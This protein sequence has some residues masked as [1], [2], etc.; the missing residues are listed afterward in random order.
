M[1][2]IYRKAEENDITKLK[3]LWIDTFE[4]DKEA[5]DI[6]FENTLKY[7]EVYC[8]EINGIIISAV[9]LI[10]CTLNNKKAHYLCG[11]STD[12]AYRKKGIMSNLIKYALDDSSDDYSVLFP[13]NEGLYSFYEKLGYVSNC[14]AKKC[15]LTRQQLLEYEEVENTSTHTNI[16]LWNNNFVDFA[17]KYY[18]HYGVKVITDENTIIFA[19]EKGDCTEIFYSDYRDINVFKSLIMNNFSSERFVLTLRSDDVNFEGET[20][21]CGM[22]KS[23][24]SEETPQEVYIGITLN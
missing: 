19:D 14:T 2:I 4:E 6:F 1:N 11:A 16:L 9:Y 3:S 21:R 24:K 5:V 7:T 17:E 15:V 8:A 12:K 20:V 23:L 13:A 18:S 10:S 22:I